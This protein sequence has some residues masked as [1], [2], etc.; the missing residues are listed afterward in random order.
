MELIAIETPRR[1][2]VLTRMPAGFACI[3]ALLLASACAERPSLIP[4]SDTSLRKTTAQFAADSAKRHYE[5]DAPQ[6]GPAP[7]RA[8]IEYAFHYVSI[9]NLSPDDWTNVEVWLNN[10]YVVNV[11][12]IPKQTAKTLNFQMLFDSD[13]NYYS[14]SSTE[15]GKS[16]P[17]VEIFH[18]G[19]MFSVATQLP[20]H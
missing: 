7:A 14:Y 10:K 8:E 2:S 11:P 5:S 3:S 17:T 18:D 1:R 19:K 16:T 4:N 9:V 12:S 20:D 6:G 13:G 15:S